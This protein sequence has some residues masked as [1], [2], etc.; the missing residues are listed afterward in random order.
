MVQGSGIVGVMM[1]EK[2]LIVVYGVP[3]SGKST[4]AAGIV[5]ADPK[6][7]VW[8][9][10][11]Q[12]R[13]ELFGDSYHKHAPVKKSENE[14]TQVADARIR[15]GLDAGL[16]VVVSDTNLSPRS[17][18][19]LLNVAGD[20]VRVEFVPV[21][22]APDVAR[23]RNIARGAAGGRR[24]PDA[25]MDQMIERAYGP[26]GHLKQ[27]VVSSRGDAFF[28]ATGTPGQKAVES[29][30][31]MLESKYPVLSDKVV[32]VD[33]DGTLADNRVDA[34]KAFGQGK[35]RDY[36]LFFK[37]IEN[38]PVNSA[39]VDLCHELRDKGY[40]LFM[41]TGRSVQFGAE[42]VRFVERSGAPLSG[43]FVKKDDD[44]RP[45]K[46]FKK[47]VLE[48]LSSAGHR[49]VAAVDDRPQSIEVWVK[50]G[51]PVF[52]VPHHEPQR[53]SPVDG[54]PALSVER[55]EGW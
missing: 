19:H 40:T 34:D 14:V 5:A 46:D 6:G 24:V 23:S 12:I 52:R 10:R 43:L 32:L 25:V 48:A 7:T 29:F 33:C 31:K 13:T 44:M 55:P 2:K 11:D 18:R 41:L 15:S 35:R 50:A 20:N 54:Y 3:G 39:V 45:D 1:N 17:V 9:E 38:A 26:D 16:V 22:V 30:N 4:V 21:D 49:V 53:V 28:V 37:N 42:L 47:E 8:V 36:N 51:V 27:I